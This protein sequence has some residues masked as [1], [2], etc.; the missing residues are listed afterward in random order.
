FDMSLGQPFVADFTQLGVNADAVYFSANMFTADGTAFPYAE[1]FEAN[2]A[3]MEQGQ[4]GFTA[5]GFFNLRA[6][7]PGTTATGSFLA[8]TV[9]PALNLDNSA[10]GAEV[11]VDT[12]D[13]P[14]P[15]SGH[16]CSSAA[17]S[18]QGLALWRLTN[19]VAHDRGGSAPVLTRTH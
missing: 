17:D 12:F 6:A 1:L 14:D 13:G 18:C 15:V 4:G 19:P 5:D 16:F 2:K 8:D 11:F 3:K 10:R 9:Q 7:G